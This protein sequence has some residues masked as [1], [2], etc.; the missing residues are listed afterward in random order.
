M[1]R[2]DAVARLEQER[3]ALDRPRARLSR[4]WRASPAKTSGGLAF[5][6][7]SAAAAAA[8]SGHSGCW[9]AGR[10]RQEEGDQAEDVTVTAIS[11]VT[12]FCVYPWGVTFASRTRWS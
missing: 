8:A 1:E 9:S 3:A 12:G 10:S 4:R 11:V 7:S 5:S 6:R 2:L